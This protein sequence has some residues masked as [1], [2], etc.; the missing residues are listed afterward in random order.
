[1]YSI[2]IAASSLAAPSQDIT[3]PLPPPRPPAVH[4]QRTEAAPTVLCPALER[5]LDSVHD[6]E[7][8]CLDLGL[9]RDDGQPNP[10]VFQRMTDELTRFLEHG[11]RGV[12]PGIGAFA[13][14]G[15]EASLQQIIECGR[16]HAGYRAFQ[17]ARS[18]D[19]KLGPADLLAG[20]EDGALT[21]PPRRGSDRALRLWKR[22]LEQERL[23]P[24]GPGSFCYVAWGALM[25]PEFWTT[26]AGHSREEFI[27]AI[28]H[29]IPV[30]DTQSWMCQRVLRTPLEWTDDQPGRGAAS[31]RATSRGT[32]GFSAQNQTWMVAARTTILSG[33]TIESSASRGRL[34]DWSR[35]MLD[36]I[37]RERGSVLVADEELRRGTLLDRQ[38]YWTDLANERAFE[39]FRAAFLDEIYAISAG[40]DDFPRSERMVLLEK[41]EAAGTL[42]DAE[43]AELQGL[44][45]QRTS[46]QYQLVGYMAAMLATNAG[47][48][49]YAAAASVLAGPAERV[50][51]TIGTSA[52]R[53]AALGR[54]WIQLGITSSPQSIWVVE[55]HLEGS[56]PIPRRGVQAIVGM[57]SMHKPP[58]WEGT[59]DA[60]FESGDRSAREIAIANP[61][62]M[63]EDRYATEFDRLVESLADETMGGDERSSLRACLIASLADSSQ[64]AGKSRL[65][66]TF[67]DGR[68][69]ESRGANSWAHATGPATRRRVLARLT[70]RER[71]DLVAKGLA[72]ASLFE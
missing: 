13:F 61:G 11:E 17:N 51:S 22:G 16:Y 1:M 35:T 26:E 55:G 44:R 62:W 49:H 31:A 9:L 14:P 47:G 45:R 25:T 23:A 68:W 53:D 19:P 57:L 42:T 70:Q 29:T 50:L 21:G 52:D 8:K 27:A 46:A 6:F 65:L 18:E 59:M 4:D 12:F 71:R 34:E 28:L 67:S 69:K 37:L 48:L 56:A 38:R 20:L 15:E 54:G 41:S 64:P 40:A 60:V 39:D 32:L 2:L 24:L 66:K 36:R 7:L 30:T 58:G 72:P 5:A 10:R 63:S 3:D 43:S 33:D